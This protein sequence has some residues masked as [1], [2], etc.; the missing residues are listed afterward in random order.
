MMPGSVLV[1]DCGS[2]NGIQVEGVTVHS[3]ELQPGAV[4]RLGHSAFRLETKGDP[5]SLAMSSRSSF[6]DLVGSSIAMRRVYAIL[7]RVAATDS[8]V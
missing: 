6:G 2:T 8:T 1:K 4:V 3:G 7:E 5:L